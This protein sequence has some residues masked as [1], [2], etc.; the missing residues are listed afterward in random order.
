M[1]RIQCLV[2]GLALSLI[3]VGVAGVSPSYA[4]TGVRRFFWGFLRGFG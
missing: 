4:A 1:N 3:V 2:K